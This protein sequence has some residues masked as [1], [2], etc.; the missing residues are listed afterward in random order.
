MGNN[1]FEELELSSDTHLPP[2]AYSITRYRVFS[3][4]MTSKSLTGDTGKKRKDNDDQEKVKWREQK[5][6]TIFK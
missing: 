6:K 4:S 5:K 2:L 1:L 3:V